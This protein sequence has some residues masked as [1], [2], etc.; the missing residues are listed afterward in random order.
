MIKGAGNRPFM[1]TQSYKITFGEGDLTEEFFRQ[2]RPSSVVAIDIETSGLDFSA[3][4]IG[5]VQVFDGA[6]T[7][8]VVRPPFNNPELLKH[9]LGS[10]KYQKV[11]HHA[12]FDLRFLR[13]HF[14]VN[15]RSVACT[16]VAAKILFPEFNCHSLKNLVAW[17]FGF[18]IDKSEQTSDWMSDSLTQGQLDYAIRDVIFLPSLL[19]D[20]L[21]YARR[22]SEMKLIRSSFT[23]IP[24]RVELD[25]LRI[26]DVFVY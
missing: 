22:R 21:H 23:Y 25:V 3:E 8:C 14:G 26:G 7:I 2:L 9:L 5:S 1:A 4:S 12:M 6:S 15:A 10:A 20:M 13:Y 17:R 16:K 18:H 24:V 11:F 19:A